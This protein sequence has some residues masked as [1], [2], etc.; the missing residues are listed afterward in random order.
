V[1]N[2][3]FVPNVCFLQAFNRVKIAS[4]FLPDELDY[5]KGASTKRFDDLKMIHCQSLVWFLHIEPTVRY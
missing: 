4:G 2:L 3:L 1:L 5:A